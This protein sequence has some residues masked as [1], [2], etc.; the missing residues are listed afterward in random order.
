MKPYT[1]ADLG[2]TDKP[3]VMRG[4]DVLQLTRLLDLREEEIRELERAA[5]ALVD[6]LDFVHK[7]PAYMSVWQISQMH[8]G[9]YMG[10]QYKREFDR[11]KAALASQPTQEP[12]PRVTVDPSVPPGTA[13]LRRGEK[14]VGRIVNLKPAPEP[15]KL[16]EGIKFPFSIASVPR[17]SY[18]DS[19]SWEHWVIDADTKRVSHVCVNG[20][21]KPPAVIVW[22]C[23][24]L[25]AAGRK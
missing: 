7:H 14:E 13:I 1:A 2:P 12:L 25:N 23:A 6:R 8:V 4:L 20:F 9:P 21:D 11:L 16:P 22:I 19:Q 17:A 5:R 15:V 18:I 24:A 10:P 3:L